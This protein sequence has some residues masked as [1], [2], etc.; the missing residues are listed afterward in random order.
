MDGW[1]GIDQNPLLQIAP[2]LL[3]AMSHYDLCACSKLSCS[4]ILLVLGW[5]FF[6]DYVL[7]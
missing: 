3:L 6:F 7:S 1:E 4:C 2:K 5:F